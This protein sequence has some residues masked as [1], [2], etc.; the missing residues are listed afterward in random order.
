MANRNFYGRGKL[1]ITGEYA[2]LDG[3]LG[4]A[5]PTTLGQKMT[6]KSTTK[7]DLHWKALDKDGNIW[8]ESQIALIDFKAIKTT[9]EEKSETLRRLL[10]GAVKLNSEFLSKWNGFNVITELEFPLDWGL[11]SSSTLT[12]LVAEW[13]D[14]HP[15]LLYFNVFN[16]SGY[17]VACAGADSPISYKLDGDDISYTP[18]DFTPKYSKNLYFVH[19]NK[20]QDSSKGIEYYL[21]NAKKKKE[22]SKAINKITEQVISASSF[23]SFSQLLDKHEELISHHLGLT[24]IQNEHFSDFNGVV[25]SLGAWGGDFVLAASQD[26]ESVV[27]NYFVDKGF[28]TLLAYDEMILQDQLV[29]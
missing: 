5:L 3:A 7:S 6:V 8:F 19:L 26:D 28:E 1:L 25:K 17:D 22:L 24:R 12:H 29:D 13:A 10:R 21:K 20:K 14:V 23:S 15:L 27:R 2:I 18:L 16:G 11:G 9:D 4:L